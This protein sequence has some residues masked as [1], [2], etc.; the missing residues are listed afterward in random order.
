[1]NAV[2]LEEA[3][4]L[5]VAASHIL[6]AEEIGLDASLGR[7]LRQDAAADC[8]LPPSDVA[9]MDGYCLRASGTA[10]AA[11]GRPVSLRIAGIAKAGAVVAGCAPG[12]GQGEC[13]AI[14]TGAALA[15]GADTVVRT[16]DAREHAGSIVITRPVPPGMH[17]RRQGEVWK[18]GDVVRLAG[19]RVTPQILAVLAA[20]GTDRVR[21]A[22]K[23]RVGILGTGDEL[24]ALG[25]VPG[26]GVL[27]ASN[28]W[29]LRGLAVGL[30]CEVETPSLCPDDTSEIARRLEAFGGCD[31]VVVSGGV[32][33]GRFDLVPDALRAI[34]AEVLF[35]G[36]R[37]RPGKGTIAAV[38]SGRAIFCLPGTPVGAF[39][40][41]HAIV[42]PALRAM[43]GVSGEDRDRIWAAVAAPIEKPEGLAR[44]VPARLR[45]DCRDSGASGDLRSCEGGLVVEPVEL[46]G[47]G[48]VVGLADVTCLV[49][50]GEAGRSV[51]AGD[52]VEV[53]ML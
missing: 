15:A 11:E 13:M 12:V 7:V 51:R 18:R 37:M 3:R 39:V 27:R 41:F 43:L 53:E 36:V 24:V 33:G 50:I 40:G 20:F 14:T 46:C 25:S 2:S 22:R 10:G 32:S 9:V 19:R 8:D 4:A 49:T 44:L 21:V 48:D 26:P 47:G 6:D 16:E 35:A 5:S 28:P 29:M 42:R 17:V 45:S 30:G 1:M 34:G 31:A 23:P 38:R 52:P